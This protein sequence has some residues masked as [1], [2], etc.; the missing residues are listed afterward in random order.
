MTSKQTRRLM[1]IVNHKT[2]LPAEVPIFREL[3]YE[4]LIP[5]IIPNHPGYRSGAVTYDYDSSLTISKSA[6]E[7]LNKHDFYGDIHVYRA[8]S[9]TLREIVNSNFDV[10]V[11]SFSGFISSLSE[12]VR[13][14]D[15]LVCARVFGLTHP[16]RY[17]DLLEWLGHAELAAQMGARGP[18]YAFVQGYENLA[19]IEPATLA[20]NPHTV[21][22][23]LPDRVFED[24]NTWRGGGEAAVFVCP[25][26]EKEGYYRSVY[27]GIKQDFGDIPHVIFGRQIEP[28]DDPVILPYLSDAELTELYVKAPVFVYPSTEARHIHYS[29]IEAMVVGAPVLYKRGALSDILAGQADSPGACADSEEMRAKALRL[30]AGDADLANAIRAQQGKI[31]DTFRVELARRQWAAILQPGGNVVS[32]SG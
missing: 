31:V 32:A 13:H 3:G 2:L 21:T 17:M 9:P 7:V 28:V 23:P 15:G 24:E 1:W 20:A 27:E 16:N 18:R 22:V 12:A 26:I 5:K 6:L 25:G 19:E 11:S 10:V 30:I 4:V 8:W 29:P 14:F